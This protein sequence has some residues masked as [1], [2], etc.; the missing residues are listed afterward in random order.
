MVIFLDSILNPRNK[1][2]NLRFKDAWKQLILGKKVACRVSHEYEVVFSVKGGLLE[3]PDY[4]Q[5]PNF[6]LK[7]NG[8]YSNNIPKALSRYSCSRFR[9]VEDSKEE[10]VREV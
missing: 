6:Y 8:F 2:Y 4:S 9:E 7:K 5:S 3:L 1:L 10:S